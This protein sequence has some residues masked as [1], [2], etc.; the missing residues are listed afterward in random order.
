MK[1]KQEAESGK[2]KFRCV[3]NC[4]FAFC[5]LLFA[6]GSRAA[7]Q[8]GDITASAQPFASGET[9]HGYAEI[10]VLLEN[11]SMKTTHRV[12]LVFPDRSFSSGNSI[13]RISR[14][15]SVGPN[16]QMLV[17]LWQPALPANGS[18]SV[19][20]EV[21]GEQPATLHVDGRHAERY[22]YG[23]GILPAAILVSRSINYDDATRV[24]QSDERDSY[25]SKMATGTPDCGGHRGTAPRAWA[26]DPSAGSPQ[27][28]ELDYAMP[29]IAKG[30]R[31]YETEWIYSIKVSVMGVSGTNLASVTISGGPSG[32]GN[33]R[34]ISFAPTKEPVKTVRLEFPMSSSVSIDAVEL[35]GVTNN[36]W[37]SSAR[38]SSDAHASFTSSPRPR[39]EMVSMLRAE[40]PVAQWSENWISY[41]PFDGIVL[42]ASDFSGLPPGV[43]TALWR[44]TECGGQLIIFGDAQIPEPWRSLQKNSSG[45]HGFNIGFGRCFVFPGGSVA[46]LNET[47]AKTLTDAMTENAR[48]WQSLPDENGANSSFA[49]TENARVP[50]R[51]TVLI[52]LGFVVV[53]GPV[54]L[55]V[56]SRMNRRVWML[57]TIPA[58]SGATCAMVFAYSLLRE[59]ITPTVRT[60]GITLL[61]Q[62]NHRA[63]SFGAVGF[64]CPLTPGGLQFSYD[65]EITPLVQIWDYRPFGNS[66][67]RREMDWSQSQQLQRG[68]VTARVPAQFHLRKSETRRERIELERNGNELSVVNGLGAGISRL[69]VADEKGNVFIVMNNIGAGQKAKLSPFADFPKAG[70]QRGPGS[71]LKELGYTAQNRSDVNAATFLSPGT[72]IAEMDENPFLEKSLSGKTK[73]APGQAHSYVYGIMETSRGL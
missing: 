70:A 53:I 66:G 43:S 32:P 38:A 52:M 1:R 50:V 10:R 30:V 55:F 23:S 71:F 48:Y 3:A 46:R 13:S 47:T 22:R 44:Y 28:L 64:Y 59:G 21:E 62:V 11:R 18:G 56:L 26:P 4:Y 73:R 25:T 16:S 33:K 67:T 20:V 17:P 65:S 14:T 60:Q 37:A 51:G 12:T 5:F 49:V 69:W 61:D 45:D 27:W 39:N 8:I 29:Q 6:F 36:V 31:I 35:V 58:I 68:W 9:F 19:R 15:V 72:Y 40:L 42:D 57:W 41:S 63:T 54:N 24:L 34:E 2:Q 7:E